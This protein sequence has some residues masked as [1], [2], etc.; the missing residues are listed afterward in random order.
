MPREIEP[1]HLDGTYWTTTRMAPTRNAP[2]EGLGYWD[3]AFAAVAAPRPKPMPKGTVK[4]VKV[5]LRST[6]YTRISKGEFGTI[7]NPIFRGHQFEILSSKLVIDDHPIWRWEKSGADQWDPVIA[8]GPFTGHETVGP[9]MGSAEGEAIRAPTLADTA[10][11]PNY[12]EEYTTILRP[13]NLEMPEGKRGQLNAAMRPALRPLRAATDSSIFTATSIVAV[14][15]PR[16]PNV[17]AAPLLLGTAA[18]IGV[19]LTLFSQAAGDRG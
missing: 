1:A 11:L 7:L 6:G 14:P 16:K 12:V 8:S 9:I 5:R 3:P 15:D 4:G 13:T 10:K 2:F 17:S 18:I 19:A